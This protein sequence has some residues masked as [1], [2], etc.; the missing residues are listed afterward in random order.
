MSEEVSRRKFKIHLCVCRQASPTCLSKK[1]YRYIVREIV[2]EKKPCCTLHRVHLQIYW[3]HTQM[4]QHIFARILE[5]S[6]PHTHAHAP[7]PAHKHTHTHTHTNIHT[8]TQMHTR[9]HTH[10]HKHIC[11][12]KSPL[13][14]VLSLRQTH[15]YSHPHTHTLSL[16]P[17]L[18]PSLSLSRARTHTHLYTIF[19]SFF[20]FQTHTQAILHTHTILFRWNNP[21][22]VE[23][24]D[25]MARST[26]E[27][28]FWPQETAQETSYFYDGFF[29][30]CTRLHNRMRKQYHVY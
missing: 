6:T 24:M 3:R 20:F 12:V 16:S 27:K 1:E 23:N 28:V 10:T 14:D 26:R 17:S 11:G 15:S 8:Q 29:F 4:Y 19:L 5:F 13:K 21:G 22:W 30:K 25:Q 7:T 2:A 9:T 18:P